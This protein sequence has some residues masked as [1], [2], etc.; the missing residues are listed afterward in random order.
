MTIKRR[1]QTCCSRSRSARAS[2]PAKS[3]TMESSRCRRSKM[4]NISLFALVLALTSLTGLAAGSADLIDAVQSGNTAAAIK[5]IDAKADVNAVSAD[6]TTALHW[7]VHNADAG[8]VD[9]LI[10]A[11][12]N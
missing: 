7:A 1:S 3:A 4:R 8:L 9:R 5:L 10:K 2:K 12:A 11:G 6:G